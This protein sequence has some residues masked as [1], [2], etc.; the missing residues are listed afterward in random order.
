M[1]LRGLSPPP[2]VLAPV[3]ILLNLITVTILA[4]PET[5]DV[6]KIHSKFIHILFVFIIK[7]DL[8][9][10]QIFKNIM[11]SSGLS[12]LHENVVLNLYA[13]VIYHKI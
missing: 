12:W 10:I 7:A 5:L 6:A 13:Y 11:L 3:E 2:E 1:G 8:P 9:P 4:K